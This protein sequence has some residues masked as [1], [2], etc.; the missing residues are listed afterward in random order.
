MAL[1]ED[2]QFCLMHF[3]PYPASP[4]D[5][6]KYG[7]AWA[8]YPNA[9]CDPAEGAGYCKR[10]FRGMEPAGRL[11]FGGPVVNGHHS[12]APGMMPGCTLMTPA[13]IAGRVVAFCGQ[14]VTAPAR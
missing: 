1:P 4:P 7:S 11:G 6:E 3:M 14:S 2:L 5:E 10:P 13:L 8:G 9:R 12:T